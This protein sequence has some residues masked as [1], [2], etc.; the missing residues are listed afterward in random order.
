MG[1]SVLKLVV[2]DKDSSHNGP[3]FFF[4]IVSGNDD[5]MF[6]V[7]QHGV[8]LTAATI[9]RRV[10]DH[11]LLRVKVLRAWWLHLGSWRTAQVVIVYLTSFLTSYRKAEMNM[12]CLLSARPVWSQWQL[13]LHRQKWNSVSFSLV[14]FLIESLAV[15]KFAGHKQNTS[16]FFVCEDVVMMPEATS[17]FV[18]S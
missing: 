8:L 16:I 4:T 2:T 13:F 12:V 14:G 6:E 10:R 5:N 18:G 9:E 7:N 1:F 3:P 11:Y 15:D 17:L